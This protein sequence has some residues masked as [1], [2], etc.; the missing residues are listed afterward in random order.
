M[1]ELAEYAHDH[2]LALPKI[3][4]LNDRHLCQKKVLLSN[5][6]VQLNLSIY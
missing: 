2:E 5:Q 1:K 4:I 3:N 6:N